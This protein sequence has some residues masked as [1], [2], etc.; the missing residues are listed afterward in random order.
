MSPDMANC[1]DYDSANGTTVKS[2]CQTFEQ[3]NRIFYDKSLYLTACQRS[4]RS[5]EVS[6]FI[7]LLLDCNGSEARELYESI[8]HKFPV[9][10]TRSVDKAKTKLRSRREELVNRESCLGN[11]EDSEAV[12]IGILMSSKAER[13][14]PLGF[15]VR[16]V[17]EFL[18]KID[19]WFLESGSNVLSSNFL[20]IAVNEFFVQGLELDLCALIWDADFRYNP[21]TNSWDYFNFNGTEWR[22]IKEETDTQIIKR[23]YLKNAYRVLLTRARAGLIIVVPEGSDVDQTRSPE[24]YNDTFNYLKS[25]GLREL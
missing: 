12:R 23:L 10:L 3:N 6:Q 16:K 2:Y 24:L 22:P 25:L 14:R 21:S 19:K 9:Y 7:Q 1:P 13:L 15:E 11:I 4:N 5:E 17:S 18:S 20:E 8:D